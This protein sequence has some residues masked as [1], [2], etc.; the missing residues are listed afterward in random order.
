MPKLYSIEAQVH[1]P[2]EKGY[3]VKISILDLGLYINGARVLPPNADHDWTVYP[4]QQ[5]VGFKYIDV[6]EFDHNQILWQE[7]FEA[8]V[9]AV[10]LYISDN[11]DEVVDVP[12]RPITLDDIPD[13]K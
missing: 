7:I 3:R 5:K 4:P 6:I 9:D 2:L 12:D 10:K 11:K 13:F 1:M 8:C